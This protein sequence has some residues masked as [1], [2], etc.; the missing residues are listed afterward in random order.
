MSKIVISDSSTLILLQRISLIEKLLNKFQIIIPAEVFD[1]AVTNGKARKF[2]DAYKIEEKIN[3]KQITVKEVSVDKIDKEFNLGKGETAAIS[4]FLQT[5]ADML[6]VDDH[7]AIN[8]CKILDIPFMT[9]LTFVVY[10]YQ[11]KL[12]EKKPA[13]AMI[14]ELSIYGR[15][16]YELINNAKSLIR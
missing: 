9:A 7:K 1:E 14:D 8:V 10:S 15:Y 13:N 2:S 4:L 5:K 16:K 12:I 6:A 3:A 11:N